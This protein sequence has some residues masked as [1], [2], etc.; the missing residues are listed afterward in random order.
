[1]IVIKVIIYPVFL[2][3]FLSLSFSL[4]IYLSFF[5]CSC[6]SKYFQILSITVSSYLSFNNNNNNDNN[7]LD[8][9]IYLSIYG[10]T[11]GVMVIVA[12]YGHG[13][14]S[15]NPGPDWLHFTKH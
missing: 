3:F 1:M 7:K 15:S 5:Y 4:S 14:T 6:P 11:R 10:G 13:D 2:S 8:S 9:D 12:G